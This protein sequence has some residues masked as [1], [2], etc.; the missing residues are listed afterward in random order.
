MLISFVRYI[1][2]QAA[3]VKEQVSNRQPLP[4]NN[5]R[6]LGTAR[7]LAVGATNAEIP[8]TATCTAVTMTLV[9]CNARVAISTAGTDATLTDHR[10]LDGERIDVAVD[11]GSTVA[12]IAESGTG[13][14]AISELV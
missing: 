7:N 1:L 14:L 6:Q 2:G 13:T 8:L 12:V 4:T 5:L 3:P 9:G 11:P 10:L